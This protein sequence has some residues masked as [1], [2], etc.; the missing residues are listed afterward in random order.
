VNAEI[1]WVGRSDALALR[2]AGVLRQMR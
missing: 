1:E 2:T